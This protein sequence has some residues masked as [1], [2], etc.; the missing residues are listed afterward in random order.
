ML[1]FLQLFNE[2]EISIKFWFFNLCEIVFKVIRVQFANFEAKKRA[3]NG[4]KS[5]KPFV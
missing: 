3:H 2:F 5:R 1:T 4:L